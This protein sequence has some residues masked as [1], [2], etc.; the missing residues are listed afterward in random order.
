MSPACHTDRAILQVSKQLRG[1]RQLGQGHTAW[2]WSWNPV[3]PHGPA[4]A[5]FYPQGQSIFFKRRFCQQILSS[6]KS[7]STQPRPLGFGA[8][9]PILLGL[10]LPLLLL[11]NLFSWSTGRWGQDTVE[12]HTGVTLATRQADFARCCDGNC[13]QQGSGRQLKG[14]WS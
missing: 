12:M 13:R 2:K 10:L 7:P 6:L 14:Q 11:A 1:M 8:A 4:V 3:H 5:P 9:A